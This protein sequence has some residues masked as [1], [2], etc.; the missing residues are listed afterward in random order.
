MNNA[1]NLNS[2]INRL[3]QTLAT[4]PCSCP[5]SSHL[6]WPGHEPNP[7]AQPAAANNSST[8]SHT[9]PAAPSH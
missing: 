6:S 7:T 2:R 9:T 1:R 5:D 8:R 3:E 4:L